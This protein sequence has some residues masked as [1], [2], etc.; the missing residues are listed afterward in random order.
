MANKNAGKNGIATRF[1]GNERRSAASEAGKKSGEIRGNGAVALFR[2]ACKEVVTYDRAV[3][4]VKAMAE[5]A[6]A[7]DPKAFELLRDTMGEKPK[8]TL[9]VEGG[10]MP[11]SVNIRVIE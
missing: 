2:A 11:F 9:E 3:G 1:N 10:E 5:R 6:D 8:D 4:F 7:G